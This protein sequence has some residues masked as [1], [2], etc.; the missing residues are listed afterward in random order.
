MIK[1]LR[2]SEMLN[3]LI[4]EQNRE[5]DTLYKNSVFNYIV[6]N[7][8]GILVFNTLMNVLIFTDKEN[9]AYFT[10]KPFRTPHNEDIDFLINNRLLVPQETDETKL[11]LEFHDLMRTIEDAKQGIERYNI[12]TTTN[13][14]ARCFY[15]YE[16]GIRQ[17]SMSPETALDVARYIAQTRAKSGRTYLRWYG[18]EPL[19][20]SK[21]I[22]TISSAMVENDIPFY[23]TISTNGYL[24]DDETI[25]KA[26]GL[27]NVKKIRIPM[28]GME[29]EHNR[30]KNFKNNKDD[31]FRKTMDNIQRVVD[32]GITMTVRLNIDADNID[33]ITELAHY[34]TEK[35]EGNPE[36][37]MYVRCLFSEISIEKHRTN[38]AYVEKLLGKK[39]EIEAYLRM[40]RIFDWQKLAPI[41]F[42]TYC[43]AA[44]N[45]NM[46][47]VVP[48]G[49]LC[50]CECHCFDDAHWG[51]IYQGI[52]DRDEYDAWIKNEMQEKCA[53]CVFLPECTP[54]IAQC[55]MSDWDCKTKFSAV[56]EDYMDENY[57]RFRSGSKLLEDEVF[58]VYDY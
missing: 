17:E 52:I 22:D 55:P 46:V 36:F 45:P 21:V 57:K 2:K 23:S 35:Y 24:I 18:G 7:D 39:K 37:N 30:R 34:L 13:C 8:D 20:N 42:R 29:A 26:T 53:G 38:R 25:E 4:G 16:E 3:N 15:C 28:D 50:S 6:Q 32:S 1:V 51:N 5:S 33:S 41:G 44:N 12:L 9:R 14:N 19:V 40:H 11:Y 27:W 54:F 58:S 47:T 10:D 31:A 49:N 43:C 56:M 48:N